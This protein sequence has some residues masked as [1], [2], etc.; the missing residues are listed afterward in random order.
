MKG[1]ATMNMHVS[2]QKPKVASPFWPW[3]FI[4]ASNSVAKKKK[5]STKIKKQTRKAT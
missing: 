1:K 5:D 4:I 3:C 2:E